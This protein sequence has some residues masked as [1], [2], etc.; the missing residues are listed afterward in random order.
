MSLLAARGVRAPRLLA[1]G[2]AFAAGSWLA[3]FALG[4]G[5]LHAWRALGAFRHL[6]SAVNTAM[7][8][9]LLLLALLSLCDALRFRRSGQAGD[10]TLKL[11]EPARQSIRGRLRRGLGTRLLI[12]SMLTAGVAVTLVE[13]LCTGQIY[14]PTIALVARLSPSPWQALGYLAG[15]NLM[16]ILLLLAV[17]ALALAGLRVTRLP[18]WS[19][20]SVILA[21]V[22]AALLFLVLAILLAAG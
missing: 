7:A 3:Y 16:F 18:Q 17:L 4:L 13:S 9:I 1:A 11:P 14:L 12:P 10:I 19:R 22:L 15:Y 21:K 8:A 20:R 6:R 2:L 5:L